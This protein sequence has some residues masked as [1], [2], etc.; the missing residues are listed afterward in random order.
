MSD[1]EYPTS[2]GFN[3]E[4]DLKY[5]QL[6]GWVLDLL[7]FVWGEEV[8]TKEKCEQDL[9]GRRELFRCL[10]AG[11]GASILGRRSNT[12]EDPEIKATVICSGVNK[13]GRNHAS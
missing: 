9:E 2:D 6:S 13:S 4:Q 8:S 1:V 11:D 7:V 12:K 10:G 3:S 5:Q